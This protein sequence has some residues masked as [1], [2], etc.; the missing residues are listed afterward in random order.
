MYHDITGI[1]LSGGKS[2]RMGENKSL[3][4]VG[5][6]TIIGIV[7]DLM[8][9]LF[10]KVILITNDPDDYTFLNLTMYPDIYSRMGPL[11]GIHSGLSHTTTEK[12]FIISCDMPLMSS[13]MIKYLI[14]FPTSKLVTI[15]KAE[16]F[17]QQLCGVYSK[18]C[19]LPAEKI[20]NMQRQGEK[21]DSDQEKRGCKVLSLVH[22]V[23]A[24]IIE[25]ESLPF[26]HPDLFFN[27]NKQDDFE[28]VTEKL[29]ERA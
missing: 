29:A 21:R 27:M 5:D 24:E 12:N 28:Y 23:G 17:V 2:S 15:T 3:M 1:I 4:T 26:Y 9:S 13:E 10:E 11:A 16:G 25:A 20:L 18:E 22:E 7:V 14:N 19:L 8:N 6:K